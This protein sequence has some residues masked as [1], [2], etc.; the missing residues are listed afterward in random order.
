MIRTNVIKVLAIY[1]MSVRELK[2]GVQRGL[3]N[4]MVLKDAHALECKLSAEVH[5]GDRR[6]YKNTTGLMWNGK[7][8]IQC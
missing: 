8:Y 2:L 1:N 3:Y 5:C 6:I 4:K 7:K